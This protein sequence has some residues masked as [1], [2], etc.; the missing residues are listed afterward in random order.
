MT[1]PPPPTHVRHP[2]AGRV[3]T[4]PLCLCAFKIWTSA[5]RR[6]A[7]EARASTPWVLIIAAAHRLSC[8]TTRNESA[9]TP[10]TSP[11]VRR[12]P[13][14]SARLGRNE[15]MSRHMSRPWSLGNLFANE[16]AS[17]GPKVNLQC[18]GRGLSRFFNS[19]VFDWQGLRKALNI[20]AFIIEMERN[21]QRD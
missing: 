21:W 15:E 14:P 4:L 16:R 19:G 10:L 17:V 6:V 2:V 3:F 5:R 12:P 20:A 8:W 1:D 9:S 13:S 7:R 11:S 18:D